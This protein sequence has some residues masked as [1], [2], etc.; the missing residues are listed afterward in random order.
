MRTV[1]PATTVSSSLSGACRCANLSEGSHRNGMRHGKEWNSCP[2]VGSAA[3]GFDFQGSVQF[4]HPLPHSGKT[5]A[6]LRSHAMKQSQALFWDTLAEIANLENHRVGVMLKTDA[7]IRSR[8]M[9]M[10]VG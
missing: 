5:D 2:Q 7:R 4:V 1:L 3:V 8:R 10:D 6:C 9:A